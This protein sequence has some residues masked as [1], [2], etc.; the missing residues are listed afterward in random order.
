MWEFGRLLFSVICKQRALKF[1]CKV[2]SKNHSNLYDAYIDQ[3]N[4]VPNA[5]WAKRVKS[6]IDHLGLTNIRLNFNVNVNNAVILK[7]R[8]YD[9]YVQSWNTSIN[10]C[11][12]LTYYCRFKKELIYESYLDTITNKKWLKLFASF[13]FSSHKLE[14]ET[15]RFNGIHRDDRHCK[16]C[17]TPVVE[18]EFHFLLCCPQYEHVRRKHTGYILRPN[19]NYFVKLM[20]SSKRKTTL[21]SI[22]K[23][24]TESYFISD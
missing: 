16:I 14:I 3:C 4:Y 17:S 22:C 11:S 5:C 6:M 19:T 20:S 9:Q 21:F 10:D 8:L 2:M 1:W 12:K 23:Y 24:L 7:T 13:R 18:D 15:G